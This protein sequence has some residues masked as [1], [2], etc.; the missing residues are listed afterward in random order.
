MDRV[1]VTATGLRDD[2]LFAIVGPDGVTVWQGAVPRMA[3]IRARCVG[4]TLVLGAADADDLTIEVV[5][6]AARRVEV[7]VEKWPG[8][9]RTA[10]RGPGA[11]HDG[12]H[13]RPRLR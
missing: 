3:T 11:P 8:L 13:R 2:R 12:R 6:D 1:E 9:A 10:Y 5:T 4:T 7:D